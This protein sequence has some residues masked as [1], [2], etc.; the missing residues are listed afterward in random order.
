MRT[1]SPSEV[2]KSLALLSSGLSQPMAFPGDCSLHPDRCV[3]RMRGLRKSEEAALF[4]LLQTG[5]SLGCGHGEAAPA[6][7]GKRWKDAGPCWVGLQ[8]GLLDFK[9]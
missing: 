9:L 7:T 1:K 5:D 6:L 3:S 4:G 2:E 8:L